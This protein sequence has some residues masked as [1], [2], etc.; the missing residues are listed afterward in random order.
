MKKV[1]KKPAAKMQDGGKVKIKVKI[2]PD[3]KQARED[4]DKMSLIKD[5]EMSLKKPSMKK[6]GAV[7]KAKSGG[8]FPDLNKDGKVTKADVLVGRGV[9]KA[10]KGKSVKKAQLGGLVDKLAGGLG[11]KA[12]GFSGIKDMFGNSGF[13][14][15]GL[16]GAIGGL[17]ARRKNK[18]AGAAPASS[19]ATQTPAPA[20]QPAMKKGGKLKKQAAVA[21]AM[22]KAGKKPKTMKSGGKMGK[23]RYG[24]N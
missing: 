20:A 10:K 13:R 3:R 6:G 1:V 24:C 7:K 12:G 8:S 15:R 2:K 11:K 9:I 14:G 5:S 23:C 19:A 22:K 18:Q 21:I 16:M 17:L 4:K